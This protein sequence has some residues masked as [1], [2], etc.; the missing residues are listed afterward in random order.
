MHG[1]VGWLSPDSPLAFQL[2]VRQTHTT[3]RT[4]GIIFAD[5]G[6]DGHTGANRAVRCQLRRGEE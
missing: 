5:M 1:M 6:R 3:Y 2:K 4:Q